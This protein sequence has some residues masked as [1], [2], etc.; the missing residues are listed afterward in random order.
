MLSLINIIKKILQNKGLVWPL[1]LLMSYL[2]MSCENDLKEV[3]RI[4][5]IQ[6]EEAVNTSYGVTVIYSD[7][8][9]VK[10]EL[11]AAE[12]R[13]TS[14]ST[15]IYE[16]PKAIKIIFFDEQ[17]KEAQRITSDYAI[18]R[19][20]SKI[21]EFR[22]NV[23]VTMADGSIIKTEEIIY[24]QA[25]DKFYNNVP[26]TAYFKD[27]RGNLQGTSFSSDKNFKDIYI[28]NSTGIYYTQG[29]SIFPSLR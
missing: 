19:V 23:V 22:K 14:D 20:E 1:F 8:A 24:D 27:N 13:E 10:A 29:Q 18:Q 3:D 6:K 17:T 11:T 25:G 7:S 12:M 5:N 4:A 26:I 21:I 2:L 9:Q 15:Q 28:A 16:F